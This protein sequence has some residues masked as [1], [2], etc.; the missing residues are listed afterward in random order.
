MCDGAVH[1]TRA[2]TLTQASATSFRDV[3]GRL[4]GLKLDLRH[5]D[6]LHSN[7]TYHTSDVSIQRQLR[8]RLCLIP[9]IPTRDRTFYIR[10]VFLFQVR[11][12][13]SDLDAL[14]ALHLRRTVGHRGL[15]ATVCSSY[16]AIWGCSAVGVLHFPIL[17]CYSWH[18]FLS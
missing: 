7:R 9:A 6:G 4:L 8:R 14:L 10:D 18:S 15:C 12:Q 3:T 13:C 5:H 2:R 1:L 17:L 16:D 11:H